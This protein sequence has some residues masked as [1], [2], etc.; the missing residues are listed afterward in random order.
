M[1]TIQIAYS[2]VNAK[3]YRADRDARLMV[4]SL[5]SYQVDGAEFTPAFK[6]NHWDGRSTFYEFK[7]DIFPAGFVNLVHSRLTQAGYN[8]QLIRKSLPKPLGSEKTKVDNFPDDPRYVYQDETIN[9]L[10]KHGQMIAQIATGGG[11]SR[12]AKL[13]YARIRRPTLFL[14]TR[15]VLMY[16]MKNT[17]ERDLKISVGIMG[18][19]EWNPINGFNVGMV[20]TLAQRI[21]L[22]TYDG[23][24]EKKLL[25]MKKREDGIIEELQKSLK[26][27]RKKPGEIVKAIADLRKE[28]EKERPS[29]F[30]LSKVIQTKVNAHNERRKKTL[31][32]LQLFEL[33]ILE[34]A[35]ESSGNSYFDILKHCA[36]AHYRLSLTA[37]P[38]MKADEEANMRLMACSG[39]IGIKVSE[40]DLINKGILAKPYFKYAQLPAPAHHARYAAWQRAYK[41]GIVENEKRNFHIVYEASRAVAHGLT[42]MV[43]V[44]YK[45]HGRTL[46]DMMSQAGLRAQF[47][48]GDD[49]QDR[50]VRE[51]AK[52]ASG[53]TQVLIGS[54]ILDVGVDVPSIGMIILAGGGKAEVALRQRIGRGL[55][56]KSSGPNVAF[57]LDFVDDHNK[58]LREHAAQR[59]HIVETT[60]GFSENI[61]SSGMDFDFAS[62]GFNKIS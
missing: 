32:T 17:F 1:K 8:V 13:A 11:K 20:Q 25:M 30:T 5:L 3:L 39:P 56:A 38:F 37:T 6:S 53:Q 45:Q 27:K 12:I 35:H 29:D 49:N 60:P 23:E 51:L 43:L 9:A 16:Q 21:E 61:L 54:T 4:S 24:I 40:K 41:Q 31:K 62:M 14:T 34:E 33:V 59:R 28:F 44:Q 50:R 26:K 2:A 7:T 52:I 36:N 42:V 22:K 57:V 58:Y 55:R 18:D 47:I 10:L 15:G 48:F 46:K 19:S